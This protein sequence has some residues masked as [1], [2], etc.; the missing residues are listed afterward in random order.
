MKTDEYI[1]DFINRERQTEPNPFLS[2]LIMS[3]IETPVAKKLTVWQS[4]AVAASISVV[5]FLGTQ[6]G[7]YSVSDKG[8][9]LNINDSEIEN[10]I[11]YND[12]THE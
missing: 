11:Y 7:R 8:I 5:I 1:N 12:E 9:A 10:F 4:I 2:T 3:R 6:L